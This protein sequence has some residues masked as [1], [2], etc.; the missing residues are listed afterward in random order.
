MGLPH[1]TELVDQIHPYQPKQQKGH[2]NP[3][4]AGGRPFDTNT[5]GVWSDGT[6]IV[7]RIAVAL[8]TIPVSEP[9]AGAIRLPSFLAVMSFQAWILGM[10]S[11]PDSLYAGRILR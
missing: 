8:I 6:Q 4:D 5:L 7:I 3:G 1:V 11:P 9:K 10:L 2:C